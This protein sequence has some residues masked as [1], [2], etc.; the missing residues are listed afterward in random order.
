[1]A[2]A[3]PATLVLVRHIEDRLVVRV[4]V[5]GGHQA[6]DDADLLV[7]HLADRGQRVRRATRR[8]RRTS[9]R[10]GRS[11]LTPSTMVRPACPW[12]GPTA[13]RAWRRRPGGVI[14]RPCRSAAREVN[15]V[16][17]STT[18][19]PMLPHGSL[20]GSLLGQDR[21]L[22]AVDHNR[23]ALGLDGARPSPH[24]RIVLEKV[25]KA[26]RIGQIIDGDEFQ[27]AL[28]LHDD[29][30]DRPSDPAETIDSY[31][32]CHSVSPEFP[33]TVTASFYG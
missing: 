29:A 7:Q 19:T 33:A 22:L 5:H 27:I 3:R 30:C 21:D 10:L 18:S 4:G 14:A 25:C 28:A 8:W 9:S 11:S 31:L 12:P 1:M 32:C 20:A 24:D 2:A 6:L 13:A 26:L 16:D 23:A 17:S 15:P